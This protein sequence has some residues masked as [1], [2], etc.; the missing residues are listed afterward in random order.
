MHLLRKDLL[1]KSGKLII[2]IILTR[3]LCEGLINADMSKIV[4][5]RLIRRHGVY[6][7]S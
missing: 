7:G 2:R 4:S 3:S 6:Y 5:Y 1:R